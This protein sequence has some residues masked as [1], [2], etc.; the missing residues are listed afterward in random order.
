VERP[1]NVNVTYSDED[2]PISCRS[3]D[4]WIAPSH[5]RVPGA[6]S[7]RIK[8]SYAIAGAAI[9]H[10][11]RIRRIRE[12]TGSQTSCCVLPGPWRTPARPTTG[13][14]S[15]VDVWWVAVRTG[16]YDSFEWVVI[17]LQ[18]TGE[19]PGYFVRYDNNPILED[20]SGEPVD[21]AGDATLVAGT[22]SCGLRASVSLGVD[23]P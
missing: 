6:H 15:D 23:E 12:R 21:I 9:C 18:G 1:D 4:N 3:G 19:L 11:S 16:G 2:G 8:A 17:K 14:Q 13:S 10:S 20:P 5:F 22:I 7:R